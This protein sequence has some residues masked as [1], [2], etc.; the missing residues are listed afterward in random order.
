MEAV[1]VWKEIG[2]YQEIG[3]MPFALEVYYKVIL[4]AF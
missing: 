4:T 2:K 1:K 3:I